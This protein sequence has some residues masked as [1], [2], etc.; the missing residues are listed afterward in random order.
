MVQGEWLTISTLTLTL[1]LTNWHTE[2]TDNTE[3]L[4]LMIHGLSLGHTEITVHLW[5]MVKDSR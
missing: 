2:I 3:Y 5:F 4:W 1:T